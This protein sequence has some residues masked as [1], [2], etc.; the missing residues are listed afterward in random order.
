M[1]ILVLNCKG[2]SI[3]YRLFKMPEASV[4]AW[5]EAQ[6]IGDASAGV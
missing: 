2:S 6:R 1:K 5:G 4:A 3:K